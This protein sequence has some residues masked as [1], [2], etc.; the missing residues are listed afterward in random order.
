MPSTVLEKT[1]EQVADSAHKIADVLHDRMGEA[2]RFVKKSGEAA[3]ELYENTT[4]EIR[5]HPAQALTTTFL[6][7]FGAGVL[8]GWL[9]RRK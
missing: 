2:K 4:R 3:E 9:L 6:V 5:R 7:A 8:T 1:S